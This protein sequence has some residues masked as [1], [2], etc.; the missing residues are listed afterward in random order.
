MGPI[1]PIGPIRPDASSC[2]P[3]NHDPGLSLLFGGCLG[4]G[5]F[6]GL[7]R[8]RPGRAPGIPGRAPSRTGPGGRPLADGPRTTANCRRAGFVC[9]WVGVVGW[10][11]LVA[12]VLAALV[13]GAFGAGL[14]HFQR[15]AGGSGLG[16][17]PAMPGTLL[18]PFGTLYD[19]PHALTRRA[20]RQRLL[21]GGAAVVGHLLHHALACCWAATRVAWSIVVSL[22]PR[23][24][25]ATWADRSDH[26]D[27]V[28]R[29]VADVRVVDVDVRH[30]GD[31]CHPRQRWSRS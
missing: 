27:V 7:L 10:L 15:P 18:A 17:T 16:L 29:D 31:V 23:A 9:G 21:R 4:G 26:G 11:L 14:R 25:P 3:V 12:G 8:R 22:V 5:Y 20:G 19:A 30:V 6:A 28:V 24:L 2:R 1:C 13:A